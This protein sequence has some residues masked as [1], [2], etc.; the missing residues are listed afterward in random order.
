MGKN[1]MG[2]YASRYVKERKGRERG[3]RAEVG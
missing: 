2:E 3:E 1:C